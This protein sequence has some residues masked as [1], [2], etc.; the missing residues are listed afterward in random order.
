MT[1]STNLIVDLLKIFFICQTKNHATIHLFLF[2]LTIQNNS[3]ITKFEKQKNFEIQ[4]IE[5]FEECQ[6]SLHL[7]AHESIE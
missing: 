3:K 4:R 5:I 6:N 2:F 7:H 1:H